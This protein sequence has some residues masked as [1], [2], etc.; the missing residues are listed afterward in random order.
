MV[1]NYRKLVSFMKDT[2]KW[3]DIVDGREAAYNALY[4]RYADLLYGY[5]MKIVADEAVVM[6]AMQ[7]LFMNIF[8]KRKSLS[9]PNSMAAYLCRSLKNLLINEMQSA[10]SK[11]TCKIN[12]ADAA[13]YDF[14]LQP[15]IENALIAGEEE[16]EKLRIFKEE[17]SKLSRQQR[18]MLYLRYYKGLAIEE[19]A[20]ILSVSKRTVYNTTNN[21]LTRLRE[22]KVLARYFGNAAIMFLLSIGKF[23]NI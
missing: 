12:D 23:Y 8:E 16:N 3:S 13:D 14:D 6:D 11:Y 1:K 9:A 18:E 22:N 10:S 17:L 21:A 2:I 4:D 5:G 19:I 7:T 20:E 15:D